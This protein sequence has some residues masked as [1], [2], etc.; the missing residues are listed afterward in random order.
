MIDCDAV[1]VRRTS[2]TK[3]EPMPSACAT[4]GMSSAL[5][6]AFGSFGVG[7]TGATTLTEIG[8]LI[9]AGGSPSAPTLPAAGARLMVTLACVEPTSSCEMSIVAVTVG[10]LGRQRSARRRDGHERFVRGDA[11]RVAGG[12]RRLAARGDAGDE[13]LLRDGAGRLRAG[14]LREVEIRLPRRLRRGDE[15]ARRPAR[16]APKSP[17]QIGAA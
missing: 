13:D 6:P 16:Y 2:L 11:E 15:V 1:L 4:A 9:G 12:E 3:R 10:A 14:E 5:N 17:P 7:V 8:T